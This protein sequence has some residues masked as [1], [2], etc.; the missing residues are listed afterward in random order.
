MNLRWQT[1]RAVLQLAT[2]LV[3]LWALSTADPDGPDD[4]D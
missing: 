4:S 1:L 2:F 3:M